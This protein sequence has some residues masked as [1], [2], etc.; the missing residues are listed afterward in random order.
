MLRQS[1]APWRGNPS[2]SYRRFGIA[3]RPS[4]RYAEYHTQIHRDVPPG[5]TTQGM[6][7]MNGMLVGLCGESS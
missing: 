5:W 6:M 7:M 3:R 2:S 1:A 4:L